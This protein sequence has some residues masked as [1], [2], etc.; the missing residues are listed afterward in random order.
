M[1]Q[2]TQTGPDAYR[3]KNYRFIVCFAKQVKHSKS[4]I[5]E[6]K[7][8]E[9]SIIALFDSLKMSPHKLGIEEFLQL[10]TEVIAPNSSA[11]AYNSY[12][13][14]ANQIRPCTPLLTYYDKIEHAEYQTKCYGFEQ[15]PNEFSIESMV[16]LIGDATRD[17]LQIPGRLIINYTIN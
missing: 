6:I 17:Y 4:A 1:K 13:K 12:E 8:F 9:K 15:T 5:N 16:N 11:A 3:I 10:A 14:I 2:L 7:N